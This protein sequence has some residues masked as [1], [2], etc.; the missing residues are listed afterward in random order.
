VVFFATRTSEW[1]GTKWVDMSRR[2]ISYAWVPTTSIPVTM[3]MTAPTTGRTGAPVTLTATVIRSGTTTGATGTVTF[4]TSSPTGPQIGSGTLNAAGTVSVQYTLPTSAQTLTIHAVYEPTGTYAEATRSLTVKVTAPVT[5]TVTIPPAWAASYKG[6]GSLRTTNP[7][8]RGYYDSTNGDQKSFIGWAKPTLP[9]GA[10]VTKV[11][12]Y[13]F[14]EWW[15]SNGG[16]TLSVGVHGH[17]SKPATAPAT[18]AQA[19]TSTWTAKSGGKWITL[20]VDQGWASGTLRGV[21]LRP[22]GGTTSQ[23]AYSY[24]SGGTSPQLRI[25][26]TQ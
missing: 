15:W 26:Y 6:D 20:P 24:Y 16:G 8:Y 11:E 9:A 25:T 1:D 7:L 12:V 4:H 3:T 2:L 19:A 5:G 22:A 13:L 17:A 10:T 14:A 21:C 18:P 23:T